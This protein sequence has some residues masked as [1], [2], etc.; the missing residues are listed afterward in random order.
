VSQ[1]HYQLTLSALGGLRIA[2]V[3]TCCAM[4]DT[5]HACGE[6]EVQESVYFPETTVGQIGFRGHFI[7]YWLE[8]F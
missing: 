6:R 3:K 4:N 2:K 1:N 7:V 5:M 8:A